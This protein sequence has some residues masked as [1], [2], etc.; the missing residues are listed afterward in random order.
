MEPVVAQRRANLRKKKQRLQACPAKGTPRERGSQGHHPNTTQT[1]PNTIQ[2][3][4]KHTKKHYL[5]VSSKTGYS[6]PSMATANPA[7]AAVPFGAFGEEV[8]VL[9]DEL[10]HK[11]IAAQA[12]EAVRAY[13]KAAGSEDK[14]V[15][16]LRIDFQCER[17]F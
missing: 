15:L 12:P 9:S 3:P 1:H 7:I 8:S 10:L 13:G 5:L 11:L 4:S 16:Y 6:F 14:D 2:T 17:S